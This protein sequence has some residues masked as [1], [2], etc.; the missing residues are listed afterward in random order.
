[1][2]IKSIWLRRIHK[3]VGL[4]IGLQFVLWA[5]SGTAMALLDMETVAGG[6]RPQAIQSAL[7]GEASGWPTIVRQLNSETIEG[8]RLRTLIDRP[9]VEVRTARST[10]MFDARTGVRVTIDAEA[11][12]AIA[13]SNHPNRTSPGPAK[14]LTRPSL[15]IRD[16]EPPIWQVDF[17]D[18]DASTYYVSATTG[19]VL[20]R[21][22]DTW[23]WW[24]FFWM[25]HNMDYSDRTSFNHPLIIT[26][27]VAMAWL[28]VT[29]FW[30]LF[31]TM[32]RHDLSWIRD[33]NMARHP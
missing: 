4:A 30:L 26:A 29:G 7:A 23:R 10:R 22:N 33:L 27:G 9:V 31:R 3:W 8:L 19:A 25:L 24:D 14:L 2:T 17:A 11:A 32:W 20:E 5:I 12:R 28:A 18:K 21:R 13:R 16:H 1:M 15:P 6:P